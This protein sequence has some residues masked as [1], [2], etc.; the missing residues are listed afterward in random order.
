MSPHT[1]TGHFCAMMSMQ[2][3]AVGDGTYDWLYIRLVLEHFAG[4]RHSRGQNTL[5]TRFFS[6]G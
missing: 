6:A 1:V 3:E 2:R 5:S 4:L